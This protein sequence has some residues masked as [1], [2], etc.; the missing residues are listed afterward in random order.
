MNL[1]FQHKIL[2]FGIV[3]QNFIGEY[4]LISIEADIKGHITFRQ[5]DASS[6]MSLN[7]RGIEGLKTGFHGFHIHENGDCADPGSHFNPME[8][9]YMDT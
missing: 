4:I 2:L 9:I 7:V 5:V 3:I 1:S 8:V 6:P